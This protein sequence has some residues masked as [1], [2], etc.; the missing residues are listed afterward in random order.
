[1]V[2]PSSP[3]GQVTKDSGFTWAGRYDERNGLVTTSTCCTIT[4]NSR[5]WR[6]CLAEERIP[7]GIRAGIRLSELL[8]P[9][10]L[11]R[12]QFRRNNF[13][14]SME[15]TKIAQSLDLHRSGGYHG[16]FRRRR[17]GPYPHGYRL[18]SRHRDRDLGGNI[19][20]KSQKVCADDAARHLC[21]DPYP[22]SSSICRVSQ[23]S[24][25]E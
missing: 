15:A 8:Y 13:D 14:D 18:G 11:D 12:V 20:L 9:A 2:V 22:G 17:V 3:R 16:V 23:R 1:V 6:K 21:G 4:R 24:A 25:S 19:C 5:T 7:V 10:V